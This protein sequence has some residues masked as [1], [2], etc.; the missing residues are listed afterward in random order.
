MRRILLLIASMIALGAVMRAQ[1]GPI[2][3][4]ILNPCPNLSFLFSEGCSC[5]PGDCPA[6]PWNDFV[7][8]NTQFFN[9][10]DSGSC[11]KGAPFKGALNFKYRFCNGVLE[12]CSSSDPFQLSTGWLYC[13]TPNICTFDYRTDLSYALEMMSRQGLIVV[14]ACPDISAIKW[15][16]C[17]KCLSSSPEFPCSSH[18][19]CYMWINVCREGYNRC[20]ACAPYVFG[21]KSFKLKYE[22]IGVYPTGVCSPTDPNCTPGCQLLYQYMKC[23]DALPSP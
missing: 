4:P 21:G 12:L 14:R 2:C 11:V 16:V 5:P 8:S 23:F 18:S 17:T 15:Y 7:I 10:A 6:V 19:Q 3:D 22:L 9:D 20:E 13:S 1:P